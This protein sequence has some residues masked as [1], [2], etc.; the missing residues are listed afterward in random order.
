MSRQQPAVQISLGTLPSHVAQLIAMFLD[1]LIERL[2]LCI[3]AVLTVFG[4]TSALM[5]PKILQ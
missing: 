5:W 1:H 2:I 3:C 4:K